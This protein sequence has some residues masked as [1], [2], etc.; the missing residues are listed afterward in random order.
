MDQRFDTYAL[1]CILVG[2]AVVI[3]LQ[4]LAR[5]ISDFRWELRYIKDELAHTSGDEHK[6]WTRKKRRLWLSLLPFVKY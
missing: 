5:F 1:L 2:A 4:A 6:R 3:I